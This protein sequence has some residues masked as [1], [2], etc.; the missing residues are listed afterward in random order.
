MML[1]GYFLF[2]KRLNPKR[3]YI[4]KQILLAGVY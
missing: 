4:I 2:K 1:K 3:K